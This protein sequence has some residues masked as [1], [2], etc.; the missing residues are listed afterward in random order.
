MSLLWVVKRRQSNMYL[1]VYEWV[2]NTKT[3]AHFA[4]R[5]AAEEAAEIASESNSEVT[6]EEVIVPAVESC[7]L[8]KR[9]TWRFAIENALELEAEE[10]RGDPL[11]RA[12]SRISALQEDW[13]MLHAPMSRDAW[14]EDDGA[15]LWWK[16]PIK[17]PP[18]VGT[19]LDDEF[20]EYVTHWTRLPEVVE[21]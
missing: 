3:A 10:L 5:K 7:P 1:G 16:M 12:V 20:P 17:E 6:I 4:T 8:C 11:E 21:P 14:H 13:A 9:I 18:Y 19:P 15:V 2:R